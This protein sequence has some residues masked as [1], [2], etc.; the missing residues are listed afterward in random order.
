MFL[1]F[2]GF[3]YHPRIYF[4]ESSITWGGTTFGIIKEM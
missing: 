3:L 2:I 1:L 4:Q